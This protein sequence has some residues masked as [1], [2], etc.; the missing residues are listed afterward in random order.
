MATTNLFGG[1]GTKGMSPTDFVKNVTQPKNPATV[2]AGYYPQPKPANYQAPAVAGASTNSMGGS[3]GFNAL[4]EDAA[5]QGLLQK[6]QNQPSGQDFDSII[7]PALKA[8]SGYQKSLEGNLP[9]IYSNLEGQ[10]QV[11]KN[12]LNQSAADITNRYGTQRTQAQQS[13]ESAVAEA[14]RGFAELQRGLQA[15]YGGTTGTGAFSAELAGRG[16]LGNINNIRTG[17]QDTMMQITDAEDSL[18]KDV[19]NK[20][21]ELDQNLTSAKESARMDLMEKIQQINLKKGELESNK[22][23]QKMD[24]MREYKMTQAQ[25]EASNK[26]FLQGLYADYQTKFGMLSKAKDEAVNNFDVSSL[27]LGDIG[28]FTPTEQK[29]ATPPQGDI[30]EFQQDDDPLGLGI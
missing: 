5:K 28:G 21:F 24:A 2:P 13:A 19:Q 6:Q 9:G 25:I 26:Q 11:S 3:G 17:L 15:Q 12:S 7:A 16:T 29:P 23:Q 1:F 10:A 27:N 22:A 8:L 20:M 18:K 14:R 30:R 4:A